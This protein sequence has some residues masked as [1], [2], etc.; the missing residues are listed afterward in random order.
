MK[1]DLALTLKT[2]LILLLSLGVFHTVPGQCGELR[3][4][5][6][7][8]L[9]NRLYV[10]TSLKP[11]ER[12][13][14]DLGQGITKELIFYVDLFRVWKIWPNEFVR[15]IK[16]KR[17]IKSNPIKREYVATSEQEGVIT[18]R[19]FRDIDTMFQWV[20]GLNNVAIPGTLSD[21]EEGTYFIRVSVESIKQKLPPAI[22]A[23]LF[24]LPNKEFAVSRDSEIFNIT[25]K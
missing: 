19:R 6:V 3:P 1:I 23:L 14:E 18:E 8:V 9:N 10:E 16:I 17:T 7:T 11:D 15:G 24:F 5:S 4:I 21:Y 13:I 22:G 20:L 2:L 25:N 12:F